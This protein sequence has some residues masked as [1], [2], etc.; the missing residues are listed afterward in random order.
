MN[1][2]PLKMVPFSKL[3]AIDEINA[4]SKSKE[5][6]DEL[7]ASIATKGLIQPLAVRPGDKGKLEI[8]D[9]RRRYLA[10][11][12]LVKDGR[13]K[14][15]DVLPVIERNED[16]NEALETSLMANTVRLPMHPV[17][18]YV[19][20]DRLTT[21]GSSETEIASRFGISDRTVKQHLALGRLAP[22]IRDAWKKGKITAD[23]ARAFAR[24]ENPDVQEAL[25]EKLRKDYG[26]Y[27]F[28][29]HQVVNALT[30]KKQPLASCHL[31][32]VVGM[33][34]YTAAG[35]TISDDLFDDE[36]YVDDVALLRKLAD[37]KIAARCAELIADGW[38]FAMGEGEA[39]A[40]TPYGWD[41]WNNVKDTDDDQFDISED[42]DP[43]KWSAEEKQVSGCVVEIVGR[44]LHVNAGMILPATEFSD[45]NKDG[46]VGGAD[47][48]DG[49]DD[50]GDS[51]DEIGE[52]DLPSAE[53]GTDLDGEDETG[54]ELK[55]SGA[56]MRTIT[57]T[58]TVTT[59]EALR[60]QPEVALR[61][62]VAALMSQGG[63]SNP[64]K[65]TA[66]GWPANARP[67]TPTKFNQIFDALNG[68]SV[69]ELLGRLGALV[70]DALDLRSFGSVGPNEHDRALIAAID[71]NA[72][73][74]EAA[75]QFN[76][77]DYFTR[78]TKAVCLEAIGE[79][80][81]AG[82]ADGLAP[83]DVLADMKKSELAD[84]AAD[85]AKRS[86]WLPTELRH[87]S[88]EIDLTKIPVAAE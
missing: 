63:S 40:Q 78:V 69:D 72:F 88:Y 79:I 76:A 81:E 17:D 42:F 65:L 27:R 70:A 41:G 8:I 47:F 48:D 14:K 87:P 71:G 24:H 59:S 23:V 52:E 73:S 46:E 83:E 11:A 4:R 37:D 56:L 50:D 85:Y 67:L 49:S 16:D 66:N 45:A 34:A 57:E 68:S 82:M 21:S 62:A 6:L 39:T 38:S 20:F 18:Q 75:K 61:A 7:A 80:R 43:A 1:E 10:F 84:A 25:C 33:D 9:G 54:D 28:G 74:L 31:I 44:E 22:S 36:K 30:G 53:E 51:D 26:G 13:R 64:V 19:V 12:M 86:G 55:I 32:T 15:S 3:A 60:R 29:V 58:L 35:G 2:I 5:G 77:V